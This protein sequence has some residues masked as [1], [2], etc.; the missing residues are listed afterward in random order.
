MY[1]VQIIWKLVQEQSTLGLHRLLFPI[2]LSLHGPLVY[3]SFMMNI[4]KSFPSI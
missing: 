1:N 2:C 3:T 4:V